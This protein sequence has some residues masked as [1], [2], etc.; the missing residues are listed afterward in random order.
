MDHPCVPRL[1]AAE[2]QE[3]L[4][5]R[6]RALPRPLDLGKAMIDPRVEIRVVEIH[7]G[8]PPQIRIVARRPQRLAMPLLD[9][10]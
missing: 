10:L 6:R 8:E 9:R 2:R 1:P 7:V 5:Q 3:L 4:R